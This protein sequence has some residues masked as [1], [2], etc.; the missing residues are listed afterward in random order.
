MSIATHPAAPAPPRETRSRW[1][2]VITVLGTIAFI[3][4]LLLATLMLLPSLLGYERYV[5]VSGS[6]EPA[7]PTGS[8]V[9]DEVVPVED[10]EVGDI[11]TFVP[12][13]EYNIEQP[14]T[15]RIIEIIAAPKGSSAA[16]ETLYRTR[17]DANEAPDAW[18]MLLD[19][20]TQA[21]YVRHIEYVGYVYLFLNQ[22][23]VQILLIGIPALVIMI[24]L[25]IALWRVAGEGVREEQQNS[26]ALE[27][28][29]GGAH[30]PSPPRPR[31]ALPG[32]G[33]GP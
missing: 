1:S 12:P 29:P 2:R 27:Q 6:M 24:F 30:E 5:I 3:L 13:P 15:H 21:R 18:T 32:D 20:D 4:A 11:I 8:V 17:G 22:R 28:A 33:V 31:P 16:G 26:P 19:Q 7:I 25:G 9:Y 14:V 23:W 10:L